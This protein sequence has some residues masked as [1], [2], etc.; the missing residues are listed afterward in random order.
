VESDCQVKHSGDGVFWAA[1]AYLALPNFLFILG[2]LRPSLALP[3]AATLLLA[4]WRWRRPEAKAGRSAAHRSLP[5]IAL[6]IVASGLWTS[7]SGIG[8]LVY[9]NPDWHVRY[10]VLRDLAVAQWPPAYTT[11]DAPAILRSSVAYYLPAALVGKLW[12]ITAANIALLPWTAAGV[13]IFFLLLPLPGRL[14]LRLFASIALVILFGGMDIIGMLTSGG[15][16]PSWPF[17]IEWWARKFQYSSITTELFWVPN[18]A[19]PAWIATA[20]LYRHR[21]DANLLIVM[22]VILAMLPLWSPF[23]A[24][25]ILP[26]AALYALAHIKTGLTTLRPHGIQI[27]A[28]LLLAFVAAC[29]LTLGADTIP[30]GMAK[31]TS[32]AP[33][34]FI[35][36]Y[37]RF[38]MFE[39]G[40]LVLALFLLIGEERKLL[41]VAAICLLALPLFR[42]G[43][44]NDLVMRASIPALV[45]LLILTLSATSKPATMRLSV[46]SAT[47]WLF[48]AFASVTAEHEIRRGL[49]LSR[50]EPDPQESLTDQNQGNTPPH[51]IGRLREGLLKT[52]L[53]DPDLVPS[54][55]AVQPQ[56]NRTNTR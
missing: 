26:F 42:F 47:F 50:W 56:W 28:A 10:A 29:Y 32:S 35:I 44:A 16:W 30:G 34:E 48:L 14:N 52:L 13:A 2:W 49:T 15:D 51:Y 6:I 18:H 4:I 24:I 7:L 12:G 5:A 11:G 8:N 36:I 39:F 31:I 55:I 45:I 23:A 21:T 33:G 46:P 27:V 40:L 25:G 1:V 37:F 19:L 38:V 43:L 54:R 3:L 22:P 17:H 9:A 20:L 53:R 41:S